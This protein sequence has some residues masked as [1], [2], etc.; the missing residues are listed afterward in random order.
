MTPKSPPSSSRGPIDWKG[1]RLRMEVAAMEMEDALNPPKDRA[2]KIMEA[3]AKAL[4]R[5]QA[6]SAAVEDLEAVVFSL[7]RETY[8]IESRFVREVVLFTGFT[9]LP[10]VPA[11]VMGVTNLRGEI[12][13]VMDLRPFFNLTVQGVT[14]LARVIVLGEERPEFGVIADA[15]AGH[16]SLA[17][18]GIKPASDVAGLRSTFIAGVTA[19]IPGGACMILDGGKLLADERFTVDHRNSTTQVA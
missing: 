19:S 3:R 9:P 2:R 15:T 16:M 6:E 8:A 13:A 4:A 1:L 5:P 10:G 12:L 18:A 7:A 17:R 11:H 14:D